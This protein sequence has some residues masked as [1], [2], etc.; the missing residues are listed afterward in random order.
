MRKKTRAQL[1]AASLYLILIAV[2]VAVLF[3]LVWMLSTS[4]KTE[5]ETFQLP[6][7]WIPQAPTAQAFVTI[8]KLKNFGRYFLNTAV[9]SVA[10]TG[11]S[12]LLSVPASYAFAR[13][14]FRGAN[15]LLSLI[16]ITQMLPSVLLVVPYFTLMRVLGLLNTHLALILAYASFSLP[17][18]I[19][20]LRGFFAGIP[21]ELD[22]A[23]M[24]DGCSRLQAVIK[25]IM[26]L[27]VPGLAATSLFTFL[28][29]WN[30][31]LFALSLATTDTMYTVSVGLGAMMGEFRIAW[32]ELMAAALVATV[33]TLIVYTFLER[34]FVQGL[35][36]GAVK[37]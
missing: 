35:T 25:V 17:F 4:F 20:M 21:K 14:R 18:C 13:F 24:V 36:G 34:Y 16:L 15:L 32:N 22:E 2:T 6:P 7:T 3:P 33:P 5:P 26:P 29:A 1:K 8:W 27:A 23:A 12:L 10:A 28:L 11:L 37:G 30:H 9:V 19:W 31:Y